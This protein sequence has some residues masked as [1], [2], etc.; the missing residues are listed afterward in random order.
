VATTR[1]GNGHK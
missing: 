1:I